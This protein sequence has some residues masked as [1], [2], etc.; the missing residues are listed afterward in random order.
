MKEK[1]YRDYEIH[2]LFANNLYTENKL[3]RIVNS[4]LDKKYRVEIAR[5]AGLSE[6]ELLPVWKERL[7]AGDIYGLYW[8][9]LTNRRLS[10]ETFNLVV[11]E[12][13]M[14]SHLNG[15]I[16]RHERMQL[17]QLEDDKKKLKL[18][19]RQS[20]S[21]Q[22]EWVEELEAARVCIGKLEKQVQ[23]LQAKTANKEESK[24][25]Q[26]ML[27]S[28]KA[29]ND[30]LHVK[31]AETSSKCRDYKEQFRQLS[32]DNADL[33]RQVLQQQETIVQLCREIKML[34][35][36]RCYNVSLPGVS[37]EK[38]ESK[39]GKLLLVGGN[40][41]LNP[42]YRDLAE[43][44]GWEYRHH[45]GSLNGGRQSLVE[46][47]KWSDL[48]LCSLDINS[49]GAVH[50]VKDVAGK[51]NKEYRLLGTSSLSGVVQALEEQSSMWTA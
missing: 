27:A 49:H 3:S 26:T 45:D 15:G 21:R 11:G 46:M 6:Q 31:L 1:N 25:Y 7:A 17:Q 22:R 10:E 32:R 8:V 40:C 36:C 18:R 4:H 29:E 37:G 14:M 48:I 13:H 51:L 30:K 2:A 12:V 39:K 43:N 38:E 47:L 41:G 23:E 50:C 9:L 35:G 24:D 42:H 20:K 19:L 44:M 28:L 33:Q 16:C 5:Y 34:V